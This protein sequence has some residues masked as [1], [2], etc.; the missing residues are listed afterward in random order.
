MTASTEQTSP[1]KDSLLLE[2]FLPTFVHRRP[3]T[4]L[5]SVFEDDSSKSRTPLS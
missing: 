2:E 4:I 5:K 1:E 3:A